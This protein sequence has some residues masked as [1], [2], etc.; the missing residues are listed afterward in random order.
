MHKDHGK[1]SLLSLGSVVSSSAL[2]CHS[3]LGWAVWTPHLSFPSHFLTLVL[4]DHLSR[5]PRISW[6][7]EHLP[8]VV[9][10]NRQS[11]GHSHRPMHCPPKG[12]VSCTCHTSPFQSLVTES[13]WP[14]GFH[15]ASLTWVSYTVRRQMTP[16]GMC[17]HGQVTP[18]AIRS[19]FV[20]QFLNPNTI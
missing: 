20:H 12:R 7:C 8:T 17:V 10:R 16:K 5:G 3:L 6:S 13:T 18:K 14:S 9:A 1:V 4:V 15:P 19:T 11:P 2:N